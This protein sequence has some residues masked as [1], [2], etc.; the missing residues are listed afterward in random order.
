MAKRNQ[1]IAV[2]YA[3]HPERFVR[4]PPTADEPAAEVWINQ[5]TAETIE[6]QPLTTT[7]AV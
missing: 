4:K 7:S 2:A 5:P 6:F 1:V 3:A